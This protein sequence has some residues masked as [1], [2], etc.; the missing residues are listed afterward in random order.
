MCHSMIASELFLRL[1]VTALNAINNEKSEMS[2]M[3]IRLHCVV[4][5]A[6][7]RNISLLCRFNIFGFLP[8]SIKTPIQLKLPV[9][10]LKG[11]LS[12]WLDQ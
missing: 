9:K 8:L 4:I 10:P 12:N 1:F 5:L 3:I 7:P 2:E 11:K 6:L